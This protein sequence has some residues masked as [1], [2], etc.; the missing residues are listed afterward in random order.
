MEVKKAVVKN[1]PF[2]RSPV[3]II[4][5]FHG[6]F[7][8][9]TK[10]IT[11]IIM[12]VKS[13]PY[14]ITIVDDCSSNYSE[15]NKDNEIDKFIDEFK[16]FD[17]KRPA[18]TEPI[19]KVLRSEKQLGFGGAAKLGFVNTKQPWV[20]L[21]HSDCVVEDTHWM[22]EMGRTLLEL[23]DKKVKMVGA[24][25]QESFLGDPRCKSEKNNITKDVILTDTFL[26]LY[27]VMFHREL[28]NHIGGF[29]KSYPYTGYEDEE[30]ALR[31][32][33]YGYKQAI[34][35]NA[36][37]YHEGSG[38]LKTL[39]SKNPEIREVIEKNRDRCIKD[40]QLLHK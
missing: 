9:V 20:M 27:C 8:K 19:L 21:M 32:N 22:I 40:V 12:S 34:C 2:S 10:L 25:S 16:N 5:P 18:G 17:A 38:T 4:I 14:Q 13:N 24:K 7:D 35:G 6:E 26:P 31:M 39:I 15:N 28:I 30:L 23:K 11:S 3:D 29:I 37:V 1:S 36:W 33:H